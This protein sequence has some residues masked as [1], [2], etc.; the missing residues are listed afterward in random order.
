MATQLKWVIKRNDTEPVIRAQ[1]K[2]LST[3]DPISLSGASA[4]FLMYDL[5]GVQVVNSP[6]GIESPA[7]EGIVQYQW[8]A[9][10]TVTSGS[11]DAEFQITLGSGQKITAPNSGYIEIRIDEDLNDS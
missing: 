10:D 7:T 11:F 1:V 4:I 5:E 3:A 2:S 6:A 9:A 8:D